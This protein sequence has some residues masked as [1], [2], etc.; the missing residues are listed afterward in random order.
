MSFL[1]EFNSKGTSYLQILSNYETGLGQPPLSV[2]RLSSPRCQSQR[3]N[4]PYLQLTN[5]FE[6]CSIT[7]IRQFSPYTTSKTINVL[8]TLLSIVCVALVSKIVH[9]YKKK[10]YLPNLILKFKK[11]IVYTVSVY[12][13]KKNAV[14]QYMLFRPKSCLTP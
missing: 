4:S 6:K 3:D 12:S 7:Q 14:R 11:M 9:C 8:S 5:R 13:T 1:P 2:Q 10:N